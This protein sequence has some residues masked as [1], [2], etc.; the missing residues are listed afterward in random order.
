L[1]FDDGGASFHS[2]IAPILE[3]YGFKG[4]FFIST[5]F[6]GT[7]GFLN[8]IQIE[9]LY[10]RGHQIGP[11]SC[12]HPRD[13]TK[14]SPDEIYSEWKNSKNIIEQIINKEV[15]IASIPSGF[16]NKK[17]IKIMSEIGIHN[18]Y[19]SVPQ[20]KKIYNEKINLFGRFAIQNFDNNSLVI[21]IINSN[22]TRLKI[23]I[24]WFVLN[25]SR[26]ILGNNYFKLRNF[27][28]KKID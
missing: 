28:I 9:D 11:H 13:M 10:N 19:T 17:V 1:T 8:K 5:D 16:Y 14:I 15:N 26:K 24:R 4:I 25:I 12:S 7:K 18:I 22:K 20:N 23:Y 21:E 6:I 3:K 27:L 2:V